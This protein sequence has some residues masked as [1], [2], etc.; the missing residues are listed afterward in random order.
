MVRQLAPLILSDEERAEL[1]ALAGRRE[2][3]QA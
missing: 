1:K 2:T 3:A